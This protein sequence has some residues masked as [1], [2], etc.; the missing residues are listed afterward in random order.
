MRSMLARNVAALCMAAAF[1]LFAAPAQAEKRVALVIGNND[2][3]YVPKLQKAVNDAKAVGD[4]LAS[5]GFEVFR[6]ENVTRLEF[7]R[8]WQRF[9]NRL[10][11]G[12]IASFFFAG[13]GV[14]IDETLAA[15]YPYKPS[16]LP[17]NRLED[18]TLWN[19]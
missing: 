7:N 18:G 14:E 17:V 15:R 10:E 13:H 8:V 4:T 5:L 3:Q 1:A 19:W 2:Y 11:P 12:D 6:G 9:L 16:A